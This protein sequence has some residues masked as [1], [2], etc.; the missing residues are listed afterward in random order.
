MNQNG[1]A[2]STRPY[3]PRHIKAGKRVDTIV[4]DRHIVPMRLEEW[5]DRTGVTDQALAERLTVVIGKKIDR[6]TVSRIRRGKRMPS[7]EMMRAL[8]EATEGTVM[9]NDFIHVRSEAA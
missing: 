8:W 2:P 7:P 6:S 3:R 4:P 1:S 5:M 9:A